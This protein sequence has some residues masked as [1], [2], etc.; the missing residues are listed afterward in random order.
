[1]AVARSTLW[2]VAGYLLIALGGTVALGMLARMP[3]LQQF[4]KDFSNHPNYYLVQIAIAVLLIQGGRFCLKKDSPE[5]W[6]VQDSSDSQDGT[7]RTPT[8]GNSNDRPPED[9]IKLDL[10]P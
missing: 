8:P 6:H 5:P 2:T 3:P 7:K 1:M 10:G 9:D 4:S